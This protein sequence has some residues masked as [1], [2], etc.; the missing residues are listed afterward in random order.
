M[1]YDMLIMDVMVVMLPCGVFSVWYWQWCALCV[2]LEKKHR[3]G[4]VM[5]IVMWS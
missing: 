1:Y 5:V 3:M 4:I 2:E